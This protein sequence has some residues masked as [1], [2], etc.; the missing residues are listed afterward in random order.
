MPSTA[1]AEFLVF[2]EGGNTPRW[3]SNEDR[4]FP[5]VITDLVFQANESRVFELDWTQEVRG[6]A[7]LSRGR[8]EARGILANVGFPSAP[9]A[10]HELG[11]NLRVFTI[12]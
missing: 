8:Y 10:P 5:T 12:D 11:S 9:L 7:F 1:G 4:A 3:R 6:G 2:A